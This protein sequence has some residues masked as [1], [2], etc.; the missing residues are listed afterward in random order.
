MRRYARRKMFKAVLAV[1]VVSIAAAT[2]SITK[3]VSGAAKFKDVPASHWAV[4]AI[5]SAVSRG[6]FKGYADGTFRPNANITRAEFAAL[7]TRVSNNSLAEGTGVFND[8]AGHWA[9]SAV[10]EAMA[11]GFLSTSDYP[12][13]FQ[14]SKPLTRKEMAKWM[15][16]G[17][18][19]KN[20]NFKQALLD[21]K[22]TLVPV[23]EFYKGGLAKSD[24]PYLSVVLGT[25]LMTG[26]PDGTFGPDKMTTRA[27]VAAILARYSNVQDKNPSQYRDLNE[28]REV[29]LTG[30]NLTSATPHVYSAIAG[31][32]KIAS[33]DRFANQPYTM[34]YNRGTMTVHR[35]IVADASSPGR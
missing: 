20:D 11:M 31:T 10:Q 13:G 35:M 29:G 1:F 4:K 2:L 28:M 14:A 16:S 30:T 6:Y 18:A 22:D 26:Y 23:A 15:S 5:D 12:N 21:T 9:Q 27:E 8:L 25:G 34:M 17:L 19:A 7:M 32:D 33:F 24:Y 3:P